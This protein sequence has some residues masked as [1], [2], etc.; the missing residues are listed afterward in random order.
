[1][2]AHPEKH[3]LKPPETLVLNC[4]LDREAYEWQ[5]CSVHF[6]RKVFSHVPNTKVAE[7]AAMLKAIHAQEDRTAAETKVEQVIESLKAMKLNSAAELVEER[8]AETLTYYAFPRS[9]WIKLK[10]NNP[11]ERLLKEVRRRT[12]VVGA[13]PDG[14][15][16]LM[17]VAA[18]LRRTA[19]QPQRPAARSAS[20]PPYRAPS[21]PDDY[22]SGSRRYGLPCSMVSCYRRP[23]WS[24]SVWQCELA[25][26]FNQTET[27]ASS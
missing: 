18:R 9:H 14:H 11:M 6:Y 17:L 4:R 2:T 16:A 22:G 5:R 13:F 7:V 23:W 20:P 10:T 25:I 21:L 19:H 27:I 15:S 24:P 12:K 26:T 3:D 8:I 1:M